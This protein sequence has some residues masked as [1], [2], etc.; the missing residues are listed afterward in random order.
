MVVGVVSAT[1][2]LKPIHEIV[3]QKGNDRRSVYVVDIDG[4]LVTHWDPATLFEGVVDVSQTAIVQAFQESRGLA[5]GSVN[6]EL[7]QDGESH[8][9]LGTYTPISDRNSTIPFL[10]DLGGA[11]IVQTEE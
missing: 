9:M 7:S 5:S 8:P 11:A 4:K 2:S 3:S 10:R 6:F 1:I